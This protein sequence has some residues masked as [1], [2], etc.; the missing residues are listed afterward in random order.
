M[1]WFRI[2]RHIVQQIH[3]DPRI[4]QVIFESHQVRGIIDPSLE[5]V[6]VVAHN[7]TVPTDERYRVNDR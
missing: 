4:L 5:S 6:V 7:S 3:F 2:F 1:G